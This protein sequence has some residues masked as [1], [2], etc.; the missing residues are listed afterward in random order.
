[1]AAKYKDV[2]RIRIF[3]KDDTTV[4]PELPGGIT[5][6]TAD[7]VV[8]PFAF[9]LSDIAAGTLANPAALNATDS[10][11]VAAGAAFRAT[12]TARDAEGA[13]T[14][15]YGRES[16]PESVRLE[17]QLIA[18]MGGASPGIGSTGGFGPFSGGAA[19]GTEFTWSEVG[20]ISA[21]PG[22]GD[23]DY[24]TAGD[25]TGPPSE[26][27]GR[28][29]PS[30]FVVTLNA[31]LFATACAAGGF[32]YQGEP[33]GYTTPP[34]ITATAVAVNGAP[35]TNYRES[36]FK[37]TNASLTGRSYTS[38]PVAALDTVGLPSTAVD[39]TITSPSDGVAALT[40]AS[41]SGLSFVKGAPQAPFA[42][43]LT[44]A[45]NVV[46]ADGVAAVG[47]GPL[48]N[49]VTFGSAA[50][51]AFTT[52]QEIRYGRI[53]IGT[54]VGSELIDLPV[55][56]RAEY[57]LSA[58]T[59]FV[60][61]VADVCTSNVALTFQTYTGALNAGDTCV[62]DG[63]APG[64]S[65]AGCAAAAL[66]PVRY[67]EPPLAGAGGDFNLRLAAPGIGNQGSVA[68]AAT[69]PAW[70]R[71]DWDASAAGDEAPTGHATFGIFGGERRLIYT[72]EI[73]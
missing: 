38:N 7:F 23:G 41:G 8:R 34:V 39:P 60:T 72:R 33:F 71:F 37:L 1:V 28:F 61:N 12:V 40:F 54:A 65:G 35:T 64:A 22:V 73:P 66:L 69:V 57:Y 18:P 43:E 4:N 17:T 32:T 36:F 51:I 70:L 29:V 19:T 26:P 6:A 3:M 27:I 5:G 11:F 50:G 21:V 25:V 63:G 48:G 56:M 47:A 14:P 9:T 10:V 68:I 58:A 30:H 15:N 2:G 45:I 44:L 59:G 53:G 62:L 42:A 52:S 13:A 67:R 24:L 20:I 16:F 55:P 46:D 49:P 31:P